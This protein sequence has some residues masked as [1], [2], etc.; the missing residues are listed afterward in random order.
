MQRAHHEE[1]RLGRL[2]RDRD[3]EWRLFTF[4]VDFF[5]HL[6][7]ERPV[8]KVPVGVQPHLGRLWSQ[9]HF[10]ENVAHQLELVVPQALV[11]H[12]ESKT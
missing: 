12:S 4:W 1:T 8:R 6:V 9:V 5:E 11:Q 2:V 3:L 7:H 10:L